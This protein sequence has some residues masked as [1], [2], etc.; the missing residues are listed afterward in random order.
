MT[1]FESRSNVV[2]WVRG[3]LSLRVLVMFPCTW[4]PQGRCS[5]SCNGCILS[6]DV[7]C[8]LQTAHYFM[9][10][11]D[12]LLSAVNGW[13]NFPSHCR[14][15]V[16][17]YWKLWVVRCSE[18]HLPKTHHLPFTS[19]SSRHVCQCD[20]WKRNTGNRFRR[21]PDTPVEPTK[22]CSSALV[23]CAGFLRFAFFFLPLW[24]VACWHQIASQM[25]PEECLLSAV[26]SAVGRHV[27][28]SI[29]KLALIPAAFLKALCHWLARVGYLWVIWLLAC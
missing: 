22:N 20:I 24:T 1:T 15:A 17:N 6:P 14:F 25:F 16:C 28:R 19:H 11:F 23:L 13:L 27:S 26:V 4:K 8:H 10:R 5:C 18:T 9:V 7:F 21:H 29:P 2:I 3:W 12:H